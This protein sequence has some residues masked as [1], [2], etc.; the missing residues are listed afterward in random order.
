L[1]N[2]ESEYKIRLKTKQSEL[3]TQLKKYD[4]ALSYYK[5]EGEQLSQEIFKTAKISYESGEINFFQYI[6]SMEN[7]LEI[8]LDYLNN[9]NIYNQVVLEINYLTI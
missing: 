5:E 2:E 9:L 6:Q 7:A 8:L 4:E 1:E 3:Y